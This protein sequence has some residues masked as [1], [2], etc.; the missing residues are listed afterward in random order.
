MA[1]GS[2]QSGVR[3]RLRKASSLA[4]P[5]V[6]DHRKTHRVLAW[7]ILHSVGVLERWAA[8]VPSCIRTRERR[9]R[10]TTRAAGLRLEPEG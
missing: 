5:L 8:P 9:R 2:M 6:K 4:R 10:K 1:R 7:H 3:R